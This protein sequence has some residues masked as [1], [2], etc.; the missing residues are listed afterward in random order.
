[1]PQMRS[2]VNNHDASISRRQ[3]LDKLFQSDAAISAA[4]KRKKRMLNELIRNWTKLTQQHIANIN[5]L[6]SILTDQRLKKFCRQFRLKDG[7]HCTT[8]SALLKQL[9]VVCVKQ[10]FN[11]S[12]RLKNCVQLIHL[13]FRNYVTCTHDVLVCLAETHVK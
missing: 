12:L 9:F 3:V 6:R 7:T 8:L 4:T 5:T 11:Q 10:V 2:Y 1:M 13:T